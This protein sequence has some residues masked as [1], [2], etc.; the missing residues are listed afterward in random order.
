MPTDLTNACGGLSFSSL[1]QFF[2]TDGESR[3]A[4]VAYLPSEE[5]L[6]DLRVLTIGPLMPEARLKD[7]LYLTTGRF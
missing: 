6:V 5:K 2:T 3:F 7:Q 1:R 4:P